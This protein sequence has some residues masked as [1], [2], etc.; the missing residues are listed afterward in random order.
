MPS[1][2]LRLALLL[3]FF[4]VATTSLCA[5]TMSER[6][7][8]LHIN[9]KTQK[10][11]LTK[12]DD[13]LPRPNNVGN[14]TF[15]G[16]STT[17]VVLS[18]ETPHWGTD[19][20]GRI[21]EEVKGKDLYAVYQQ[22][23]ACTY[24]K[25][26]H[27][28]PVEGKRYIFAGT[29]AY[30]ISKALNGQLLPSDKTKAD[31]SD[32][33]P[34]RIIAHNSDSLIVRFT[35]AMIWETP[36]DNAFNLWQEGY[37]LDLYK[38]GFWKSPY[39]HTLR[40]D[41]TLSNSKQKQAFVNENDKIAIKKNAP[42]AYQLRA[43][44]ETQ[45]ELPHFTSSPSYTIHIGE[46]GYATFAAPEAVALPKE[47]RAFVGV[48]QNK[49]TIHLQEVENIIPPCT[50]IVLQASLPND[51]TLVTQPLT[52]H[53]QPQRTNV[54]QAA[55][56]TVSDSTIK[57][58]AA[59]QYYALAQIDGKVAFYPVGTGLYIPVGKAYVKLPRQQ[60]AST[61][62]LSFDLAPTGIAAEVQCSPSHMTLYDLRGRRINTPRKGVIYLQ[63]G[64]KRIY[65]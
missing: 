1:F 50:A 17:P 49:G 31:P 2:S 19:A 24:F 58:D 27:H 48:L 65:L 62:A 10:A 36:V 59:Y 28:Q 64:K 20:M 39:E 55:L 26:V 12:D 6:E 52:S 33:P 32:G 8:L 29:S 21:K 45:G 18:A 40:W 7:V 3:N 47:L 60:S 4:W 51:Y 63:K 56:Q 61:E 46:S 14:F 22:H 35:P 44:E 41:N 57:A 11:A 30:K 9:G 5:A 43:F 25:K 16:W 13:A 37:Y 38:N 15:V 54:L 34:V 23:L 42:I 53:A